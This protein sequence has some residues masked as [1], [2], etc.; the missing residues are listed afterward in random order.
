[1]T[2]PITLSQPVEQGTY[3]TEKPI[4][5]TLTHM[6]LPGHIRIHATEPFCRFRKRVG[7][8][9]IEKAKLPEPTHFS[10]FLQWQSKLVDPIYLVSH[11]FFI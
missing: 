2:L 6:L 4:T 9:P 10:L 1:M 7:S 5:W 3:H 8:V 11:P